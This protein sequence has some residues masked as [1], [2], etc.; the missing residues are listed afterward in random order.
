MSVNLPTIVVTGATGF[1]GR[2]VI[3]RLLQE[4]VMVKCLIRN[5]DDRNKFVPHDNL[6][7]V[8]G[9]ITE[10][11][12]L[13]V[14]FKGAW[15]VINIAGLREFWS[16][17]KKQ[18]YKLNHIGAT[19]VFKACLDNNIQHVVQVST[20]LA[21]GAPASIPFNEDTPAGP[22][23]SNYGRSKYLGDQAGLLMRKNQPFNVYLHRCPSKIDIPIMT[24]SI[25]CF[26]K[27]KPDQ[28]VGGEIFTS[29]K[30]RK[31]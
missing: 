12:T 9:D 3:D 25:S 15:G 21:F 4:S 29:H 6:S 26:T 7:F 13:Q 31:H 18:F 2:P 16:Q 24:S 28:R 30:V 14:A 11:E 5:D 8:I 17:D 27:Y 20:P 1:V 10:I 19:N 23:P 22:H